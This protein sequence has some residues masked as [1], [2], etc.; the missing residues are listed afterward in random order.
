MTRLLRVSAEQQAV[1]NAYAKAVL[2]ARLQV[3]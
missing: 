2:E 1:V 3:D